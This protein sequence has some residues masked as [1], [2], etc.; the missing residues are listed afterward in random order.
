[1]LFS[2]WQGMFFDLFLGLFC[3]N[4]WQ[5]CSLNIVS[6]KFILGNGFI[7]LVKS[8]CY[9]DFIDFSWVSGLSKNIFFIICMYLLIKC[10]VYNV[11]LE[12]CVYIIVV[13]D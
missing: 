11:I 5:L 13:N 6:V 2:V 3:D 4:F 8:F 10:N 1:M 9:F 12:Y 7:S